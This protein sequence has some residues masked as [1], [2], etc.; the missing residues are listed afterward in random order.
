M[1]LRRVSR[2]PVVFPF[3]FCAAVLSVLAFAPSVLAQTHPLIEHIEPTAGPP[4]TSVRI[5]GRGFIH[6]YRVLFDEHP[7]TPEEVLPERITVIVP[8]GAQTGHWVLSNGSDEVE[9]EVFRVTAP[10]AP[11]VI[12]SIEPLASSPGGEVTLHGDHFAARPSDNSVRI[13]LLPM[14][15][16]SGDSVAL[17]VIVP[18]G[19]VTGPVFVRIQG[20]EGRSSGDLTIG[21][22]LVVREVVPAAATPG[23]RVVLHGVGFSTTVASNHVT[24]HGRPLR[25]LHATPTQLDVDLPLDATTGTLTVD[26]PGSGHYETGDAI[27]VGPAPVVRSIDPPSGSPGAR[28]TLHGDHLGSDPRTVTVTLGTLPM[29]VVSVA[30]GEIIATVPEGAVTARVNVTSAGIGP[31]P[32]P[33]DFTVLEALTVSSVAPRSG[34]VGDRVTLTGTGFSPTVTQDQVLLGSVPARVVS[35]TATQIVV[36]VPEGHSAPWYVTVQG[37]GSTHT[38]EGFIV[39]RRPRILSVEPDRG[40]PGSSVTLHGENLPADRAL[41]SVRLNG[42]EAPITAFS[43]DA[44]VVTVPANAQSGRFELIGRLQGTGRAPTDFLV[45]SPVTLR[46]VVPP[47]GPVGSSVTLRGQGFEPDVTRLNVHM[48]ALLLHPTQASTTEIT[49]AVPRGARGGIITVAADGRQTVSSHDPFMVTLPP[50]VQGFAPLHGPVGTRITLRGSNLGT[51][52]GNI[53]VNLGM[54]ACPV[55]AVTPTTVTCVVPEGASSGR[56]TVRVANVGEARSTAEYRVDSPR[57]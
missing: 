46:E 1:D 28:V 7:V 18:E 43:H 33:T 51:I 2:F 42:L 38:R 25:V 44:V 40:P 50:T 29:T 17:H 24:L 15:V 57:P 10:E 39:A 8:E 56:L 31:V 41:A 5:I 35:A 12:T 20:V 22:R 54:L 48:G 30:P 52:V 45:V 49:F 53:G 36:E 4:G 3:P 55:A 21:T 34:D 47:A 16:R 37:N 11:P 23:S 27:F 26:V 6:A 9:S 14:V 19:A 32:S 13:G